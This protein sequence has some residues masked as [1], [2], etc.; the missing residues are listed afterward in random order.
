MPRL[1]SGWPA[2]TKR[3]ASASTSSTVPGPGGI[4][5]QAVRRFA[6]AAGQARIAAASASAGRSPVSTPH[7]W[8][9]FMALH[10]VVIATPVWCPTHGLGHGAGV[11]RD[12]SRGSA[13]REAAASSVAIHAST[14]RSSTGSG[15]EPWSS[16]APWKRRMSKR[17]PSVALA[18]S[19]NSMIFSSPTM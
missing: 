15:T 6:G 1:T 7:W 16:T 8:A 14:A 13:Q 19:R 10:G 17:A 9:E 12:A 11:R 18:R 4:A 5:G 2:L 3:I